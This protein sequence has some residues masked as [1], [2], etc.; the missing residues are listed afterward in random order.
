VY[1]LA[2]RLRL[3]LDDLHPL[4]E[5]A[6]LL[7]WA[8][9]ER[10]D[11]DLTVEGQR[12]AEA[13]AAERKAL[14]RERV[15]DLPLVVSILRALAPGAPVPRETIL[16]GLRAQVPPAEAERQ[17]DTAVNWGRWAELFDYDADDACFLLR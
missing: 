2:E 11:Y 6:R 14:F 10:G 4:L 5:A 7:G 9:V 16:R 1:R 15:R 13:A 8:R 17:V 12:V 3:R